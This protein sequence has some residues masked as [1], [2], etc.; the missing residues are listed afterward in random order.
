M[1][2]PIELNV[3][4]KSVK[5]ATL[6]LKKMHRRL[7][8]SSISLIKPS[9]KKYIFCKYSVHRIK[10]FKN[11][12]E[13][14]QCFIIGTGPSLNKTNLSLL[15]DKI[16]MGVNTL[17]NGLPK[18]G[19]NCKYYCVSD[20]VVWKNHYR[21]ILDLDTVLFLSGEA[22]EDYIAKRTYYSNYRKDRIYVIKRKDDSQYLT[23]ISKDITQGAYWGGTVIIDV[24][25]QLAYYMG[26]KNI[27][28]LGCDCDYSGIHR[29]DGTMTDELRGPGA[30]GEWEGIFKSY[31][32]C[33]RTFEEAGRR[34]VNCTVGGKLEV[35]EREKLE[36]VI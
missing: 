22:G 29:F 36:D 25:L 10:K 2:N 32:I 16:V 21:K 5:Y 18:F 7:N 14:Q 28:L 9:L 26:F 13:G 35:F 19:I 30:S 12:H 20:V 6:G 33:K 3:L 11:I 31:K 8:R 23:S 15:E 24:C 4:K 34:I 27:Y 17:Y 1:T